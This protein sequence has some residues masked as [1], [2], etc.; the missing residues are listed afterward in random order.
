MADMRASLTIKSWNDRIVKRHFESGLTAAFKQL[1]EDIVEVA[2]QNVAEGV[3]PGPHP[4]LTEHE[5][6]GALAESIQ[7]LVI[8]GGPK[9][10]VLEV[11][12]GEFYGAI[13]ELGY[14]TSTGR[15]VQYPW[16]MPAVDEQGRRMNL[17]LAKLKV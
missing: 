11:G 13:L 6:T 4:H 3:G 14:H 8:E 9:G 1:G 15:W 16:L 7:P 10:P 17:Y 12:F 5:D 2:R